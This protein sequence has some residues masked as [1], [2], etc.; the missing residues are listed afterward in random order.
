MGDP[1][2]EQAERRHFLLMKHLRLRFLQLPRPLSDAGFE[3]G[4]VLFQCDVEL[5]EIVAD[6][7]Q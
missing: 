6:A 2:R 1:C 7:F 5:A 3:V 4:L